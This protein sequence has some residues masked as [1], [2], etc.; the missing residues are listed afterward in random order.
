MSEIDK[1]IDDTLS[2]YLQNIPIE[3]VPTKYIKK[4][5][6]EFLDGTKKIITSSGKNKF[7]NDLNKIDYKNNISKVD[8][9][10]DFE[11]LKY[12]I[13]QTSDDLLNIK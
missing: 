7:M 12:D 13:Q 4:I 6:V 11:K 9:I 5:Y 1:I 8:F 3:K 10:F 2:V